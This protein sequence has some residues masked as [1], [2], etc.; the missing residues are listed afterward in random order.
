[1]RGYV[2][3]TAILALVLSPNFISAQTTAPAIIPGGILNAAG[4]ASEPSN[5][6]APG[7]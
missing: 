6:A 7:R 2:R 3:L 1:M 4:L 5:V